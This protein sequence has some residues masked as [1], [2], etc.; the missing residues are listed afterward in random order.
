MKIISFVE[1]FRLI[2]SVLNI[3]VPISILTFKLF[4]TWN[5]LHMWTMIVSPVSSVALMNI[6]MCT[7]WLVM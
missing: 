2:F 1:N 3:F 7:N 4:I 6:L 5:F